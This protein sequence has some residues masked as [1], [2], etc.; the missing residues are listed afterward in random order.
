MTMIIWS[1]NIFLLFDKVLSGIPICFP[2]LVL[3]FC[4]TRLYLVSQYFLPLTRLY[5]ISQQFLHPF[6]KKL[7]KYSLKIHV[8]VCLDRV[9]RLYIHHENHFIYITFWLS[10]RTLLGV[11]ATENLI[12]MLGLS[13]AKLRLGFASYLGKLLYLPINFCIPTDSK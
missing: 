5:L 13:C 3:H 9:R 7:K 2:L 10:S 1:P 11:L 4:L 12:L 6:H 8:S